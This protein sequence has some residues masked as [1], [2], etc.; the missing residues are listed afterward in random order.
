MNDGIEL[1][2]LTAAF[3]AIRE[4]LARP[5][6]EHMHRP[7]PNPGWDVGVLFD[8]VMDLT[9]RIGAAAGITVC[10]N[11]EA[12]PQQR[13]AAVVGPIVEGWRRRQMQGEIIWR[14]RRLT[15]PVA[16]NVLTLD[17]VVHGWD[18]AVALDRTLKIPE[19][20]AQYLLEFAHE[21]LTDDVRADSGF[22]APVA[23]YESSGS[24]L[25]RLVAFTGRDPDNWDKSATE[26][27]D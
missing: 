26:G 16:I 14:T 9:V 25:D 24:T 18:L 1:A 22:A 7:T 27:V 11:I 19:P 17:I 5:F 8:H 4:M 10:D 20:R 6:A 21:A 15:D 12:A 2:S 23:G 13:L 3:E